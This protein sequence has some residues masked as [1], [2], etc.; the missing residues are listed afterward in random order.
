MQLGNQRASGN[1]EDRRGMGV[2]GGGLGVGGIVIAAHRLFPRL[3]SRHRDQRRRAG[4]TRSAATRAKRPRARP[5][6]R[7][8]SSSPRCSGSTEDVWSKIFQ[9]SERQYRA[10]DAR[11]LRRAGALGLRHGPGGD[12]AVLLPRRREAL[13]RPLVLP[14]PADALPR[15]GRFRAGLCD[16]ARSRPPRAEAHRHVPEA[17]SAAGAAPGRAQPALRCAWSCRPTATPASGAT[18]PAA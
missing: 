13:H 11:A 5:P 6:T 3:R 10:P 1:V 8:G 12:G 2:V 16:R 7:W 4:H 17:G 15:A 18:T 14:R 9:Q